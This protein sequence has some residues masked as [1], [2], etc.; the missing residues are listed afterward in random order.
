MVNWELRAVT[1]DQ[2]QSLSNLNILLI[3]VVGYDFLMIKIPIIGG[4]IYCLAL[5]EL[6]SEAL[7]PPAGNT[8]QGEAKLSCV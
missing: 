1:V 3:K 6:L 4:L 2:P 5:G 7:L 8:M